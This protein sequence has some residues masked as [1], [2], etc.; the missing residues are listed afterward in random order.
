[1]N[2]CENVC[3][4]VRLCSV[5]ECVSEWGGGGGGGGGRVG[6]GVF[7]VVLYLE[8]AWLWCSAFVMSEGVNGNIK[9]N[10]WCDFTF[11]E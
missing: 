4:C 1:M 8:G 11:G 6:V 3:V 10:S 2:V 9:A 5:C 7:V